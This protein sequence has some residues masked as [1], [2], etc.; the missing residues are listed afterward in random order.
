ML[1]EGPGGGEEGGLVLDGAASLR[2]WCC[3][4]VQ[5]MIGSVVDVER[6]ETIS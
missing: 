4:Y 3:C 6:D 1:R 2:I 5:W